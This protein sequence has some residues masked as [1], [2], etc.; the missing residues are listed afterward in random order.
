MNHR[1]SML[2][3][4]NTHLSCHEGALGLRQLTASRAR[5][6]VFSVWLLVGCKDLSGSHGAHGYGSIMASW[7]SLL[8]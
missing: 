2:E 4:V 3:L 5:W 8:S 1:S 7:F 6:L